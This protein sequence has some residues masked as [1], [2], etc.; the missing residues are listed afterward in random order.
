MNGVDMIRER[1]SLAHR[2]AKGAV[3]CVCV[4]LI[5][6]S[7]H[8][9]HAAQS[10]GLFTVTASLQKTAGGGG[11]GGG[12]TGGGGGSGGGGEVCRNTAL[13]EA[14]GAIATVVCTTGAL[15]DLAPGKKRGPWS[16]MH[17]GAYRFITQVT[18][19]GEWVDAI[20]DTAGTGTIT[21]WRVVKLPERSYLELTLGW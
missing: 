15:V 2:A 13:T 8:S 16:P 18:W 20:D 7:T 6:L 17:G 21:S 4:A 14:S 3:R 9:S 11:G 1:G 5:V 12:G 19:N 10:S